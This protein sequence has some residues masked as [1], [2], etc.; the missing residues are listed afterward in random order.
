MGVGSLNHETGGCPLEVRVQGVTQSFD[1]RALTIVD[2]A[3]GMGVLPNLPVFRSTEAELCID[4]RR[5][6]A[7][8]AEVCF[9]HQAPSALCPAA[10]H[11]S[12]SSLPVPAGFLI[13]LIVVKVCSGPGTEPS[14][15]AL[16]ICMHL[17]EAV[18]LANLLHCG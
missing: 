8:V 9:K 14:N 1:T 7:A 16:F 12:L 5:M 2:E 6:P 17:I 3:V 11:G 13:G 18:T 10:L 15:Q 4:L